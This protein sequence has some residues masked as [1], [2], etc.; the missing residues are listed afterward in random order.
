MYATYKMLRGT[1]KAIGSDAEPW[2]IVTG[3][4]LGT[5]IGFLPLWPIGHGPCIIGF[6]LLFLAI[7]INCHLGSLFLFLFVTKVLGTVLKGPFLMVGDQFKGL[8]QWSADNPILYNSLCSNTGYLGRTLIGICFAPLFGILMYRLVVWARTHLMPRLLAHRKLVTAG[9][10]AD[11]KWLI[12]V[13]CW[14]F[15]V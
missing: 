6:V 1:I 4:M 5:L 15:G 7:V 8:A 11:R 13:G 10:V 12:M 14:F 9:K 3:T 2:Q